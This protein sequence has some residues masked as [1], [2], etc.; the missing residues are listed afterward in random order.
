MKDEEAVE[1]GWEAT[2]GALYGAAKWGA[3]MAVLGGIGYAISP[4]YRGLTIQFKV[5]VPSGRHARCCRFDRVIKETL[6]GSGIG[7]YKC[8]AWLWEA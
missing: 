1:A 6:T 4:I 2:R 5:Y 3:A 8:Q 7:T